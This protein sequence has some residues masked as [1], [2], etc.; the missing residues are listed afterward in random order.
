MSFDLTDKLISKSF[1]NLLQTTGSDN[2][3]YDLKGN[4][5]T[6]LRVPGSIT[7]DS[8]IVSSSVS[9]YTSS[10]YSGST[11][12]GDSSD[13]THTF[14]GNITSSGHLQVKRITADGN[15]ILTGSAGRTIQF[16]T[17]STSSPVKFIQYNQASPSGFHMIV[18][19]TTD[20]I[21][22]NNSAYGQTK[23]SY[24]NSTEV[25]I[26]T[27]D[28]MV[29]KGLGVVGDISASGDLQVDGGMTG[30]ELQL[31]INDDNADEGMLQFYGAGTQAINFGDEGSYYAGRISYS[32][33]NN[34][35]AF[36]TNTGNTSL[37]ITSQGN[38]GIKTNGNNPKEFTVEGAISAS[39]GISTDGSITASGAGPHVF[40]DRV[41]IGDNVTGTL[42]GIVVEGKISASSHL[43]VDGITR[44]SDGRIYNYDTGGS[45]ETIGLQIGNNAKFIHFDVNESNNALYISQSSSPRIGIG[46]S[47]PTVE[48]QVEGDISASGNLYLQNQE[49]TTLRMGVNTSDAPRTLTV[50]GSISGSTGLNVQSASINS[51]Q[52]TDQALTVSGGISSSG[53][54]YFDPGDY[55]YWLN[56]SVD[57]N[58]IR[59]NSNQ[60][61]YS[62]Y[63]GHS[64]MVNNS[65]IM[66]LTG[67]TL[68]L[69][70]QDFIANGYISSSG[71]IHTLSHITASGN[72]SSSGNIKSSTLQADSGITLGSSVG[73][74]AN[75][76]GTGAKLFLD[77]GSDTYLTTDGE[78]NTIKFY[79]NSQEHMKL[80][81]GYGLRV[82]GNISASNDIYLPTDRYIYNDTQT[83]ALRFRDGLISVKT[84][85]FVVQQSSS[86]GT[87]TDSGK[88]VTVEG[89]ISASGDIHAEGN[90]TAS[91][92]ISASGAINAAYVRV[93]GTDVYAGQVV[94]NLTELGD[95]TSNQGKYTLSFSGGTSTTRVISNL[96]SDDSPTFNDLHLGGDADITGS[97]IISGSGDAELLVDGMVSSSGTVYASNISSSGNMHLGG[98][99]TVGYDNSGSALLT[100]QKGRFSVNYGDGTQTTGSLASPGDGYGEIVKFGNTVTTAGY[101]Y[102][103]NSSGTWTPVNATD[104]TKG[105]DE[106]LAMS[107]GTSSDRDGML[108][109]GFVRTNASG[110]SVIGRALYIHTTDGLITY[111]TSGF[112]TG[113][114]VRIVGYSVG[115]AGAQD[116]LYFNPGTTWVTIS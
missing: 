55:I 71:A 109:R 110:T 81:N 14:T 59:M 26:N 82:N 107:L 64:W 114:I 80:D 103:L 69:W 24:L 23:G 50:R 73:G 70:N 75:E 6:D 99:L 96:G 25:V 19:G 38:V 36:R 28:S 115:T 58:W 85:H 3:L 41:K 56:G 51:F 92:N 98:N 61:Y 35:M 29:D 113:N 16:Q 67:T 47:Y 54:M 48:L 65:A 44:T 106:L 42:D 2:I 46:T 102:Y 62:G 90:I 13:D 77:G 100:A 30:S 52:N 60:M 9:Y 4:Q 104:N 72:I 68:Q 111:D 112:S 63:T 33:S 34:R 53:N 88:R 84:G 105:A 20:K 21:H 32:H 18:N 74:H 89:D 43:Y 12:F 22:F 17:G 57:E 94:T 7:A 49:N 97:L 95:S 101:V 45:H 78:N 39:E 40:G 66:H 37:D 76:N 27:T 10:Y 79:A 11:Q 93:N 91:G 5:V 86:F 31:G 87:T 8:Y 116:Q 108:L 15:L 83:S 1:Q